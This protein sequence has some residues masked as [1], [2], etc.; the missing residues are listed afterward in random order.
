MSVPRHICACKSVDVRY[1]V[2]TTHVRSGSLKTHDI[3]RD[4]GPATA[5]ERSFAIWELP[6]VRALSGAW[7]LYITG[8]FNMVFAVVLR[9]SARCRVVLHEPLYCACGK[10]FVEPPVVHV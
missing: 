10:S 9:L 7:L 1:P 4:I 6:S 3:G 2:A 5:T 8:P